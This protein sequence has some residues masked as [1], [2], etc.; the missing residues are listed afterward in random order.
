[1]LRSSRDHHFI[2]R[3]ADSNS[4]AR[5]S[6]PTRTTTATAIENEQ[7]EQQLS[8]CVSAQFAAEYILR[9]WDLDLK[10]ELEKQKQRADQKF[11]KASLLRRPQ[12]RARIS[13]RQ[14]CRRP[15]AAGFI[16]A[17]NSHD[18]RPNR[19]LGRPPP[20]KWMWRRRRRPAS[21]ETAAAVS[22]FVRHCTDLATR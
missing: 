16:R 22:T 11:S 20:C 18:R 2:L 12:A 13:G 9:C 21:E 3:A 17:T 15:S 6:Q 1:M 5:S 4:R 10:L 14:K 19:S 8:V 7:M